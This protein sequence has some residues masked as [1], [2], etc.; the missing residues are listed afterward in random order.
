M[1]VCCLFCF[2]TTTWSVICQWG[3]PFSRWYQPWLPSLFC[4]NHR[5]LFFKL[6]FKMADEKE[7]WPFRN[8]YRKRRRMTDPWKLVT[9]R[10]LAKKW[11]FVRC[12]MGFPDGF[13]GKAAVLTSE[14]LVPAKRTFPVTRFSLG[15][16][17]A[18][19]PWREWE[20]V[21]KISS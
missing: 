12:F 20:H 16:H 9:F 4:L 18:M 8:V 5:S 13:F 19:G 21:L 17:F 7:K 15:N 11:F 3:R 14:T 10:V 6:L 2:S 1:T